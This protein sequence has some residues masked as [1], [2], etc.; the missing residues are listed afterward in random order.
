M[1]IGSFELTPC[2]VLDAAKSPN[3]NVLVL[4]RY[5][6]AAAIEGV[7]SFYGVIALGGHHGTAGGAIRELPDHLGEYPN[8]GV[9]SIYLGFQRDDPEQMATYE[10]MLED[11]GREAMELQQ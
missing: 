8:A 7:D 4:R 6:C 1:S 5:Y 9:A 10:A 3:G 2:A 11:A